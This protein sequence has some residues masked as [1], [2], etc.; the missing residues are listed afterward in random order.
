MTH[1]DR[2]T[3]PASGVTLR[4]ALQAVSPAEADALMRAACLA[5]VPLQCGATAAQPL[6]FDAARLQSDLAWFPEWCVSRHFG[7]Q[8]DTDAQARWQRVCQALIDAALAQPVVPMSGHWT[9][10]ALPLAVV[11]DGAAGTPGSLDTVLAAASAVGPVAFDLVALL[12]DAAVVADPPFSWD[13]SQELDWAVRYWQAARLAGV[14]VADDFGAFWRDVEW[15]SFQRHL[16]QMGQRCRAFHE[17]G[18]PLPATVL[19]TL[20]AAASKLA[21]RYSTLKPVL[22]LLEPLSGTA[23]AAGYTF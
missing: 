15:S 7:V 19:P 10:D 8:W 17:E 16:V 12:R 14:P 1:T 13:E 2:A 23:V 20:L 11:L 18:E 4:A 6:A 5:L 3:H 9:V 22:R 21:L